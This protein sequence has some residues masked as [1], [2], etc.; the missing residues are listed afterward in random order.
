MV[1]MVGERNKKEIQLI[2][3]F[4]ARFQIIHLE[5]AIPMAVLKLITSYAKT[6]GW[7]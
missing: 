7:I 1:L 4:I 6:T 2:N 3:Q 5:P